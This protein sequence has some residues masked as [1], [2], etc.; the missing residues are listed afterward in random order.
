MFGTDK[1]RTFLRKFP[2]KT[3]PLY[4]FCG[5]AGDHSKLRDVD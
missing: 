2:S 5:I 4:K 3:K 1:L